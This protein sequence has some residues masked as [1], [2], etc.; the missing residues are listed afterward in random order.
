VNFLSRRNKAPTAR[1]LRAARRAPYYLEQTQNDGIV[2]CT[3]GLP[4]ELFVTTDASYD[5]HLDSKSHTGASFHLG[6]FS[7]SFMSFSKKQKIT[8]DS[9]TVAEFIGA[10]AS[11]QNIAWVTNLLTEMK[12]KLT[13]PATLYQDNIS[14]INILHKKG[15][16]ARTKHIDL[17]FNSIREFIQQKRITVKHLQTDYMIA[18]TLTKPL[19]GPSFLRHKIRLLNLSPPTDT[20]LTLI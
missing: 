11:C 19:S 2:F 15:N 7:G 12:I 5:C 3:Y 16:E 10:H 9:S 6:R 18:D 1:D 13:K 4:F 17:R 20:D 8:A 14:T